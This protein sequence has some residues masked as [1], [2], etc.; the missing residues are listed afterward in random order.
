MLC[1]WDTLGFHS[2]TGMLLGLSS[3]YLRNK[4]L[5]P[6][7]LLTT[8]QPFERTD[9]RSTLQWPLRSW[10]KPP[11]SQE[12]T[13]HFESIEGWFCCFFG[14]WSILLQ[15]QFPSLAAYGS[16]KNPDCRSQLL[17]F[18]FNLSGEYEKKKWEFSKAPRCFYAGARV[19]SLL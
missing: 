1:V 19:E 11:V 2:Q 13:G 6:V 16:F 5:R 15:Q 10:G 18:W 7:Y 14:V 8:V 3:A 17:R 9:G 4:S 12:R